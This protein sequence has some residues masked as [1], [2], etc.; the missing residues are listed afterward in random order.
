[1]VVGSSIPA[2]ATHDVVARGSDS[3]APPNTL[4]RRPRKVQDVFLMA[5]STVSN[6][7]KGKLRTLN[8]PWSDRAVRHTTLLQ[9]LIAPAHRRNLCAG[10][11]KGVGAQ[12]DLI[13]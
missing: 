13:A 4:A 12:V 11:L 5:N 2:R 8:G 10:T 7:I 3:R 1:M 9:N 6:W